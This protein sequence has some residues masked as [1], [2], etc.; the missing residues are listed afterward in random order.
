MSLDARKKWQMGS[1]EMKNKRS[2]IFL[3]R[4]TLK[5]E[6]FFRRNNQTLIISLHQK[7]QKIRSDVKWL[8]NFYHYNDDSDSDKKG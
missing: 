5:Q 8:N 6:V 1:I 3:H 7:F 4:K 2:M